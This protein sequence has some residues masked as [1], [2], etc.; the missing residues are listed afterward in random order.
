MVKKLLVGL[1]LS[2]LVLGCTNNTSQSNQSFFETYRHTQIGD[3]SNVGGILSSL[4]WDNP[5][6]GFELFTNEEPYGMLIHFDGPLTSENMVANASYLFTLIDNLDYVIYET[7]NDTLQIYRQE[8]EDFYQ[9][10]F[11]EIESQDQLDLLIN[12]HDLGLFFDGIPKG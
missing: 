7:S 3:N 9:I 5:Y 10:P 12:G 4:E 8:L 6:N 2:F 1:I 11:N